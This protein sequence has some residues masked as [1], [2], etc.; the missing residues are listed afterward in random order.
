M[1]IYNSFLVSASVFLPFL[2]SGKGTAG[3]N[4]HLM[5]RCCILN[6]EEHNLTNIIYGYHPTIF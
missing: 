5:C 4:K 1:Y 2:P 3:R 6:G